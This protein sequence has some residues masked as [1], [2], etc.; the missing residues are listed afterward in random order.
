MSADLKEQKRVSRFERAEEGRKEG[1]GEEGGGARYLGQVPQQG[2]LVSGQVLPAVLHLAGQVP[3]APHKLLHLGYQ[4]VACAGQLPPLLPP[5]PSCLLQS[6]HRQGSVMCTPGGSLLSVV[7]QRAAEIERW[8]GKKV[9][10]T[11]VSEGQVAAVWEK[12][13][14]RYSTDTFVSW[15]Q[16]YI[17]SPICI[18]CSKAGTRWMWDSY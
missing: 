15:K 4:A 18:Q 12:I 8:R 10:K 9:R 6:P 5:Q 14:K 2:L 3:A 11:N 16:H 1:E 7:G 17:T 13:N